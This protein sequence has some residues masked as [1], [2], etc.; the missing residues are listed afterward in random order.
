LKFID[1]YGGKCSC[2]GEDDYRFLTLDHVTSDGAEHRKG[3][4]DA[5]IYSDAIKLYQ[6]EKYQ[7]LCFNCNCAKQSNGGICP[8]KSE[9]KEEWMANARKSLGVSQQ[10]NRKSAEERMAELLDLLS[11][12]EL[13]LLLDKYKVT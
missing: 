7:V 11:P 1:R 2:C 12:K 8:H 13:A 5:Q 4:W 9:S 10:F 3:L 6:P